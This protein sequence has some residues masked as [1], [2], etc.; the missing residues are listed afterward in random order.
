MCNWKGRGRGTQEQREERERPW[1]RKT[2]FYFRDLFFVL[3]QADWKKYKT[4]LVLNARHKERKERKAR[5][6]VCGLQLSNSDRKLQ[7]MAAW[8]Q[9][10][11][12]LSQR[13]RYRLGQKGKNGWKC[14]KKK[15]QKN[16]PFSLWKYDTNLIQILNTKNTICIQQTKNLSPELVK[17]VSHMSWSGPFCQKPSVSKT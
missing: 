11:I 4:K 13:C 1:S 3:Q 7:S 15:K 10:K 8:K 17:E 14:L 16:T 9:W 2:A 12:S 5:L 6:L